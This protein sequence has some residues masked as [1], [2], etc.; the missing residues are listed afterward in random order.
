MHIVNNS[1]ISGKVNNNISVWANNDTLE[2]MLLSPTSLHISIVNSE[3]IKKNIIAD[4]LYC[5]IGMISYLKLIQDYEKDSTEYAIKDNKFN[6]GILY[7]MKLN[8]LPNDIIPRNE[9]VYVDIE[10][11]EIFKC[12]LEGV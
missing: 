12:K 8:C 9:F 3:I 2:A 7:G 5:G 6:D 11:D 1:F 4:I 10:M